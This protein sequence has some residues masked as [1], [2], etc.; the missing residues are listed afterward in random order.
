MARN[1]QLSKGLLIGF[2]TGGIVGAAIALLYA[3]KPGKELRREILEKSEDLWDDAR[4]RAAKVYNEG[5]KKS[6]QLITDAKVKADEIIK[7]AEATIKAAKEKT[8]AEGER[9]KDAVK[10]GVDAYKETKNNE[11]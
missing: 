1:G 9:I 5:R 3:P 11:A 6:D 10:A 8:V 7:N 2:L 4:E